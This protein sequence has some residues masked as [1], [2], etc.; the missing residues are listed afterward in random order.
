MLDDK[1]V[2]HQ[3]SIKQKDNDNK[4]IKFLDLY[5]ADGKNQLVLTKDNFTQTL[6]KIEKN[7]SDETIR[8]ALLDNRITEPQK[9]NT[10]FYTPAQFADMATHSLENFQDKYYFSDAQTGLYFN[11]V[12]INSKIYP[13]IQ[14]SSIRV[15]DLGRTSYINCLN[16]FGDKTTKHLDF[17]A[18]SQGANL[19]QKDNFFTLELSAGT[20][21]GSEELTRYI[22]FKVLPDKVILHR[23]G[24][25]IYISREEDNLPD[26]EATLI[27]YKADKNNE[28]V[29][30]KDNMQEKLKEFESKVK[31][32]YYARVLDWYLI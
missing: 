19:V 23:Y 14:V 6:T 2:L 12:K 18:C 25:E 16:V 17:A 30:G 26:K 8:Q 4:T 22:T 3:Y 24:V 10:S 29:L 5:K 11:E 31:D 1:V 27:L 13:I 20:P 7:V 32:R 15:D 28:I 21:T 9:I